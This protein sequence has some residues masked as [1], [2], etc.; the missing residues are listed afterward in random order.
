VSGEL[1]SSVVWMPPDLD[2][3][4]VGHDNGTIIVRWP[5]VGE[6][7][8]VPGEQHPR[9]T[10]EPGVSSQFLSKFMVTDFLACRRYLAGAIS[11]HGAAVRFPS[12][13]AIALV[14]ESGV[15]KSTTAMAI[16]ERTLAAFLADDVV[17][18]DWVAGVPT[19]SPV[20]DVFWLSEKTREWLGHERGGSP[21]KQGYEPRRRAVESAPLSAVVD[22]EFSSALRRPT[23]D[24]LTGQ[25]A[26][27]AL[28]GAHVCY[29]S[30]TQEDDLRNLGLRARL[31]RAVPIFR[32]R[33]P[34]SLD[35]LDEIAY[36]LDELADGLKPESRFS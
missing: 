1:A 6:L 8:A 9:F 35:H 15:G 11:L 16:V 5:G 31:N 3:V 22:L 4:Q 30:G 7:I 21:G 29:R 12:G 24:R 27:L 36:L 34:P 2:G 25:D 28:S 10:P 19:L 13:Q 20:E 23:L 18:V 26:F 17:P 14:G 33:R 32:L